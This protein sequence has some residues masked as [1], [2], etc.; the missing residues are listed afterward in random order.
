[1][2][3]L[4]DIVQGGPAKPQRQP[5]VLDITV[6]YNGAALPLWLAMRFSSSIRRLI[7][8]HRKAPARDLQRCPRPDG[9]P[10][11]V[12]REA[13][14]AAENSIGLAYALLIHFAPRPLP[15]DS[16]SCSTSA[17]S[18]SRT[19]SRLNARSV[20]AWVPSER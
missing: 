18:T 12:A 2:D 20:A 9:L 8:A 14:D 16:I 6:S 15:V 4:N 17:R 11:T 7:G 19:M 5:G 1:M 10:E 13:A 3:L